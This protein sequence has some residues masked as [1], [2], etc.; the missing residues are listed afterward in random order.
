M[1][2]QIDFKVWSIIGSDSTAF[3]LDF[4][5]LVRLRGYVTIMW[6]CS[7]SWLSSWFQIK[8]TIPMSPEPPSLILTLALKFSS[9]YIPTAWCEDV[10]C[11]YSR[12]PHN[13]FSNK[14]RQNRPHTQSYFLQQDI[15]ILRRSNRKDRLE[16]SGVTLPLFLSSTFLM[17]LGSLK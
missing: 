9:P 17:E 8:V 4:R 1:C 12:G 5:L 11:S 13:D 3:Q 15:D 6:N 7:K 14:T 10:S 2:T 16:L